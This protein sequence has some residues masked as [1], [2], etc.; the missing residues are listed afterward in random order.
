MEPLYNELWAKERLNIIDKRT[1]YIYHPHQCFSPG[2]EVNLQGTGNKKLQVQESDM[3]TR[4]KLFKLD[5]DRQQT[6]MQEET[7]ASSVCNWAVRPA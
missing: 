6:S 3:I 2:Y 5:K 4:E 1:I 7:N